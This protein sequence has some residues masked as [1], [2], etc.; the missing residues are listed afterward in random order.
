MAFKLDSSGYKILNDNTVKQ[1]LEPKVNTL[2]MHSFN[3]VIKILKLQ[4][5]ISNL[6]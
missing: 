4:Q 5:Q 1:I 2:K 3:C 6:K